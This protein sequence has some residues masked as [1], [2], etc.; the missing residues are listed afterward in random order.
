MGGNLEI[1][2]PYKPPQL[3]VKNTNSPRKDAN[4]YLHKRFRFLANLCGALWVLSSAAIAFGIFFELVQAQSRGS[5]APVHPSVLTIAIPASLLL[6]LVGALSCLKV[7]PAIYGVLISSYFAILA[8][9]LS[10]VLFGSKIRILSLLNFEYFL[11][12][13][14]RLLIFALLGAAIINGHHVVNIAKVIRRSV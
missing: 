11:S 13:P 2:N 4:T 8:V 5:L 12:I 14:Y 6:L 7:V 1:E 10:G 9:Y 3:A